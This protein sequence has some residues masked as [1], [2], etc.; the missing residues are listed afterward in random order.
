MGDRAAKDALFDGFAEVGKALA[1]GRRA[2]VVD[3]LAQGERHVEGIAE[4]IGQ[5]VANTS[6]HLRCLAG[7]GLVTTR[8][9]GNRVYYRLT[10][11][12]V[13]A[14]WAA[15]RD[16]AVAHH[17]ELDQLSAAY[18][19]NRRG[20]EEVTRNELASRLE[21]GDLVVLDVRPIPEFASGHIAGA[22]SIPIDDLGA[23]IRSLPDRV[24]VV[25]Y[26][27][28]PF[29]VFADDAVRLLRRRGRTARRLEDGFP[30]WR[31]AGLPV[32]EGLP[33]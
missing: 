15:V 32:A 1:N 20:I 4:S 5:S 24:E 9:E 19:G 31:G 16:V 18:L 10:S 17:T 13:A 25:A 7:A 6:F 12:R 28:G 11:D 29:C 26:C 33:A 8:R 27:R 3:V 23:Q 21:A 14:L 2:E 30:E 22:R